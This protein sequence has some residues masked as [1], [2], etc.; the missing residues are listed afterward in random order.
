MVLRMRRTKG[1]W[2]LGVGSIVRGDRNSVIRV[3]NGIILK[4][5]LNA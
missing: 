3:R 1:K 2:A 4:L 5:L